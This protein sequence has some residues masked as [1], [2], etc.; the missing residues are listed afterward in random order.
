MLNFLVSFTWIIACS[1]PM[2]ATG[3]TE[4][5]LYHPQQ[6]SYG[7]LFLSKEVPFE[8]TRDWEIYEK[9]TMLKCLVTVGEG[10]G[11]GIEFYLD[12]KD[13]QAVIE[14]VEKHHLYVDVI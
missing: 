6:K 11:M 12:K 1:L 2:N 13:Q 10:T 9:K 14:L 3:L 8:H 7:H 4:E 5:G